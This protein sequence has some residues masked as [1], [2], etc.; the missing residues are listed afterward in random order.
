MS[1]STA[2]NKKLF[3]D[4][5]Y[6]LATAWDRVLRSSSSTDQVRQIKAMLEIYLRYTSGILLA[7]YL[8]EPAK[9]AIES[10]LPS[11]S[12]PANG[13][14]CA[15]IREML[16]YFREIQQESETPHFF[17]HAIDWYWD[18]K[19]RKPKL[20]AEAKRLDRLISFRNEDTHELIKTENE[21]Y[22]EVPEVLQDL[23]QLLYHS[24]WLTGYSLF[25]ISNARRRRGGGEEGQV[26]FYKG[27]V[28]PLP[29]P[30]IWSSVLY[31]EV[32]YLVSPNGTEVL[33]VDPFLVSEMIGRKEEV[34]LWV[35]TPNMR[36]IDLRNDNTG[37]KTKRTPM[38]GDDNL[39]WK[40]WLESRSQLEPI[41][42]NEYP[43][44]FLDA[45][46]QDVGSVIDDHYRIL[47]HL[48]EG[49]MATVYEVYDQVMEE[50]L[51]LKI[52]H[53]EQVD[54][55]I[56]DR[57]K[58]EFKFMQS[59]NHA[60]ILPVKSIDFLSDGRIAIG[61]PL[62]E[63][64]LK[65]YMEDST[66]TEELV[67]SWGRDLL[68]ALDYLHT[69]PEP[70]YH[71][72]I[73]P[74]NVLYDSEGQIYIADF[75]IARQEGD[76]RLT[77]TAEQ[78][79][80]VPYMAPE[81][82]RGGEANESTDRYS[83]AVAL[84][85]LRV[86][87][88]PKKVGHE[89][90][91]PLGEVLQRL[92]SSEPEERLTVSVADFDLPIVSEEESIEDIAR[93]VDELLS[94]LGL[95]DESV[96]DVVDGS[97]DKDEEILNEERNNNPQISDFVDIPEVVESEESE[98][99]ELLTQQDEIS[100]FDETQQETVESASHEPVQSQSNTNE[101][102]PSQAESFWAKSYVPWLVVAPIIGYRLI[103]ILAVTTIHPGQTLTTLINAIGLITPTYPSINIFSRL[104]VE[105][106]STMLYALRGDSFTLYLV[107]CLLVVNIL[108]ESIHRRIFKA[109]IGC[110]IVFGLLDLYGLWILQDMKV[111]PTNG[112]DLSK[113]ATHDISQT[114]IHMSFAKEFLYPWFMF[115]IILLRTACYAF[116]C[117]KIGQAVSG[118]KTES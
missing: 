109:A 97:E 62:M 117:H 75:G 72:D 83:L 22:G 53:L 52:L 3:T 41:Q 8:R 112:S 101:V 89:I 94:A 49:G 68:S 5:P 6:P 32:M 99:A 118:E 35:S 10:M 9:S 91:G 55:K 17:T 115:V 47:R 16:R 39:Q 113:F 13:H 20:T 78:M 1:T 44:D 28:L 19:S 82:L 30:S 60:N 96:P 48:G 14:Y 76:V 73:K 90:E 107:L 27:K 4:L 86:G 64:T 18:A 63:G 80:S 37:Y 100:D 57:T 111:Y 74:S 110:I 11:L 79:G 45:H 106:S 69:L 51:A 26:Q 2:I 58:K 31:P 116:I 85:E 59:L 98:S 108:R 84:H 105:S 38:I 92:G 56:K 21:L 34:S 54:T 102:A 33:E 50:N 114:R 104:S 12:S 93:D 95:S 61:M 40:D 77:R 81:T 70:I 15:L 65:D 36:R 24:K 46:F 23:Q 29:Q 103:E 42:S 66:V 7:A 43:T 67:C 25:R 87:K 88:L 71:R